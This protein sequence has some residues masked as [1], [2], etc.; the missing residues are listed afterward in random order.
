MRILLM[1]IMIAVSAIAKKLYNLQQK[2]LNSIVRIIMPPSSAVKKKAAEHVSGLVAQEKLPPDAALGKSSRYYLVK[3]KYDGIKEIEMFGQTSVGNRGLRNFGWVLLEFGSYGVGGRGGIISLTNKSK[4]LTE[5]PALYSAYIPKWSVTTNVY[6]YTPL[7]KFEYIDIEKASGNSLTLRDSGNGDLWTIARGNKEDDFMELAQYIE[8]RKQGLPIQAIDK[9]LT[10]QRQLP[11]FDLLSK[12]PSASTKISGVI[13]LRDALESDEYESAASHL[14]IP[15][16]KDVS[17]KFAVTDLRKLGNIMSAGQTGSGKSTFTETTLLVSL[18]YRN[19]PEDLR[20]LLVD[21]KWVQFSQ[22]SGLPHLLRPVITDSD[23]AKNAFQWLLEESDRRQQLL[24]V[25]GVSD[26]DEYRRSKKLPYIVVVIDE[27]IDL[28]MV[29]CTFYEEAFISLANSSKQTGIHM[30][31]GTSRPS[32]DAYTER[33]KASI[34]ARIAFAMASEVDSIT[35]LGEAGA[36]KLTG[37][38]DLYFKSA[39]DA[40]PIKLQSPYARDE[41]VV[42]VVEFW[43]R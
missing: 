36:E 12:Y 8:S 7:T 23:D 4:G 25:A 17:G 29:D 33:L 20:L 34:P 22:Y 13:S 28:F 5:D 18:L 15:I 32:P 1:N 37:A 38:G 14:A 35:L 10:S 40:P 16:G 39:P 43:S 9:A 24:A 27:V 30:Y 26:I 19:T 21:P 2:N 41:D 6:Y 11:S 3:L 31:F 42:K